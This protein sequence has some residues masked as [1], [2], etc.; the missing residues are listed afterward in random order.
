MATTIKNAIQRNVVDVVFDG[1][2]FLYA[3]L[4]LTDLAVNKMDIKFSV[5]PVILGLLWK[6]EK[7]HWKLESSNALNSELFG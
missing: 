4:P 1:G 5:S 2:G 6:L 7:S 3:S